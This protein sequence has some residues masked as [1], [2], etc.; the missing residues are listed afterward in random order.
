MS[1]PKKD[2]MHPEDMRNLFIFLVL[3][4]LVY[5]TY[6]A[7]ILKP[8][9]AAQRAARMAQIAEQQAQTY[10]AKEELPL[11]RGEALAKTE[12]LSIDNGKVFGTI[13]LTGGRMDD[14]ALHDY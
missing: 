12:R 7:L 3:A 14:I 5:F 11:P 6:D 2:Q 4:T 8:H 1:G 9:A 10:L 13:A